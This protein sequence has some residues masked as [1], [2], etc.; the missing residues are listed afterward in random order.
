[1]PDSNLFDNIKFETFG[2]ALKYYRE[3]KGVSK[4]ALA[5]TLGISP[6]YIAR[7][8]NGERD[9]PSYQTV[10][11]LA[12]SLGLTLKQVNTL[13]WLAGY[14]PIEPAYPREDLKGD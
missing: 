5:L 9:N 4:N 10:I 13:L 6:S 7:L 12:L 11:R 1:M 8:E 2:D 14:A 3:L